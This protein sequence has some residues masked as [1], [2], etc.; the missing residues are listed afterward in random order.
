MAKHRSSKQRVA[1]PR[2]QAVHEMM[3]AAGYSLGSPEFA[4]PKAKEYPEF[5]SILLKAVEHFGIDASAGVYPKHGVLKAYF[6][7]QRLS[8]GSLISDHHAGALATFCRSVPAM[9]GG[10]TSRGKGA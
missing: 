10:N 2:R 7:R 5:I 4:R 3:T 9:K 6:L 1:L 8:D